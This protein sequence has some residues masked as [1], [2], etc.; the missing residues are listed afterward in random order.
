MTKTIW[1]AVL[2]LG[3]LITR[4]GFNAMNPADPAMQELTVALLLTG[5][6]AICLL[7]ASGL[8]GMLDWIPL[9]NNDH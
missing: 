6:L 7:A 3:L 8:L 5:G 4:L 1:A 2:V 9:R